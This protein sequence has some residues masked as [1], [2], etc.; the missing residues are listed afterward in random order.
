MLASQRIESEKSLGVY[1]LRTE[2][3]LL[4][5]SVRDIHHTLEN[6][7]YGPS[8]G[9]VSVASKSRKPFKKAKE[10]VQ[11]H[12]LSENDIMTAQNVNFDSYRQ[13]AWERDAVEVSVEREH[14]GDSIEQSENIDSNGQSLWVGVTAQVSAEIDNHGDTNDQTGGNT[15]KCEVKR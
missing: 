11:K 4:K 12:C 10:V 7:T 13:P 9:N 3:R 1:N 15:G 8:P 6:M 2:V 5:D 14:L